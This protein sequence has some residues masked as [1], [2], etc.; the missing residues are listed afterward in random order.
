MAQYTVEETL[1]AL[2][3]DEGY[4]PD[5]DDEVMQCIEVYVYD[6]VV[7]GCCRNCLATTTR[8]EPDMREG[9]C[10]ACEGQE[11]QSILVLAGI[12]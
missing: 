10:H 1:N 12:M 8:C 3:V 7:P 4:D 11:V 5:N 6:S 9:W 2:L